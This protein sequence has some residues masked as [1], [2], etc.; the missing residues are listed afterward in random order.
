MKSANASSSRRKFVGFGI[1]ALCSQLVG[2]ALFQI[3]NLKFQI[4][5]IDG[6]RRIVVGSKDFT[7]SIILAEILAQMLEKKGI[8]GDTAIRAWRK[9]RT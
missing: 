2:S 7:E 4:R 8:C 3:S 1:V 5:N 6:T 9:S